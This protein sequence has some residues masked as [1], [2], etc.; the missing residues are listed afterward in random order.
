MSS[1]VFESS[2]RFELGESA[3]SNRLAG[4]SELFDSSELF[5]SSRMI[6]STMNAS[7]R[8]YTVSS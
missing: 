6:E 1:R 5:E 4:S 8:N 7:T 2:V 3:V